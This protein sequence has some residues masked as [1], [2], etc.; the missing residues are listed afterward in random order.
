MGINKTEAIV[1]NARELRETSL[2]ATFY[3]K[4]FGKISGVIKGV[5]GARAQYFGGALEPFAH[6]AIVFYEKKASGLFLVSQC[7]LINF[8]WA[9]RGDLERLAYA[10]YLVELL[11]S[12]TPIGEKSGEIFAL[13]ARS[14]ELLCG[15][16]SPRR[17]A[18]IFEIMLLKR[19][20]MMPELERCVVC[21][22]KV[23][24]EGRFNLKLGGL[25]CGPCASSSGA[26]I[27]ILRGTREF[28]RHI[29]SSDF[30]RA[31]RIKVA[32]EVGREVEVIL[33]KFIDYHIER[34][35]NTVAF[36]TSIQGCLLKGA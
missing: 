5:R 32:K 21:G 20:G 6:D 36:L 15:S 16:A 19:Q 12:A 24:G 13:L 31:S 28:M 14:L 23:E 10:S 2:I 1:L 29:A 7:E 11:D 27:P 22:G 25:V 8:F 9:L 17:V 34:R 4:D 18:R 30:D 33:R 3:T 35:L 26:A